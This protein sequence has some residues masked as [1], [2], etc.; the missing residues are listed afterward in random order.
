MTVPLLK[1]LEFMLV[2]VVVRPGE[3]TLVPEL[4]LE[5]ERVLFILSFIVSLV[6]VPVAESMVPESVVPVL[7]VPV[8]DVP[9][10]PAA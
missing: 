5:G 6:R 3:V 4:M 8:L 9:V 10:V 7:E 2:P 1:E